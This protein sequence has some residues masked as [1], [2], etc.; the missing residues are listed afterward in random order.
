[1]DSLLYMRISQDPPILPETFWKALE[2]TRLKKKKLKRDKNN[3]IHLKYDS[4]MYILNIRNGKLGN[5]FKC[6]FENKGHPSIY[7]GTHLKGEPRR[8][9]ITE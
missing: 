3:N 1:M 5:R 4:G 9:Q 8:K 2:L 7:E 6:I